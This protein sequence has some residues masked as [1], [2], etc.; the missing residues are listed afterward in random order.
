[1][2]QKEEM[3]QHFRETLHLSR[4][5]GKLRTVDNKN[6]SIYYKFNPRLKQVES[7]GN[8]IMI[9][10]IRGIAASTGIPFRYLGRQTMCIM[11]E[12]I[13]ELGI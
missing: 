3:N 6:S 13:E 5:L 11:S 4:C 9:N 10:L 1:M 7:K 2:S 12:S 8:N